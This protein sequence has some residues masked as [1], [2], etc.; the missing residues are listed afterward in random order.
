M[1]KTRENGCGVAGTIPPGPIIEDWV[2][3]G[4][5]SETHLDMARHGSGATI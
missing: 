4:N 1:D 3:G 5:H 2:P